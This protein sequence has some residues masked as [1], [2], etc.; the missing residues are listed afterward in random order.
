MLCKF[1]VFVKLEQEK[2]IAMKH[3]FDKG[4]SFERETK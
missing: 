3:N 1:T 4:G 2:K